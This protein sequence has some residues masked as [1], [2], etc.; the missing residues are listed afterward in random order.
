M[1]M[2][3]CIYIKYK[4]ILKIMNVVQDTQSAEMECIA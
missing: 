1:G 4:I 2:F 3:D